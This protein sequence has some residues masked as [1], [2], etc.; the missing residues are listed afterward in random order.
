MKM[1]IYDKHTEALSN[2]KK[3][4]KKEAELRIKIV[5]D[6]TQPNDI[7]T[8][9]F[10]KCGYEVKITRSLAYSIDD[11]VMELIYDDLPTEQRAVVAFKPKLILAD[12][13][14]L[15]NSEAINDAIIVKDSMPRIL[16][17]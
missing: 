17:S 14:K 5:D 9:K 4:K 6:L 8:F 15:K 16:I 11:E 7:G 13:K 10:S 2:L 12:Y 3:W 1:N